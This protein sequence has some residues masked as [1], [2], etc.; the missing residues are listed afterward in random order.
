MLF[1]RPFRCERCDSR[2]FRWSFTANPNSARPATQESLTNIHHHSGSRRAKIRAGIDG[3]KVTLE[4]RDYGHGI[5]QEILEGFKTS[6]NGVGVGLAGIR[7]RLREVD[8]RLGLSSSGDGT[9]LRVS[10]LVTNT[11]E[12]YRSSAAGVH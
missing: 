12:P 10:L 9:I 4:I 8:G 5:P 1:V 6:G 11:R 7:E 2:F 3:E